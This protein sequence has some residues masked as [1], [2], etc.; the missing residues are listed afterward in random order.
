MRQ[1]SPNMRTILQCAAI[2]TSPG[3]CV[4]TLGG[5]RLADY[6]AT[7]VRARSVVLCALR[8]RLTPR[9]ARSGART[10][11]A[12][13]RRAAPLDS[14]FRGEFGN[15]GTAG[16]LSQKSIFT[17]PAIDKLVL[18]T[19]GSEGGWPPRRYHADPDLR[20]GGS[21]PGGTTYPINGSRPAVSRL[22]N[23]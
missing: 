22:H 21:T 8:P 12:E 14:Q 3:C 23:R 4:A 18:H 17:M 11:G 19:T 5:S 1:T 10:R 13:V 9:A 2:L 20:A 6:R 16:N 15:S 7:S